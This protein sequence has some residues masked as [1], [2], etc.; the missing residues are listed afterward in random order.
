MLCTVWRDNVR[1][2]KTPWFV[3]V[4]VLQQYQPNTPMQVKANGVLHPCPPTN[5][6][7]AAHRVGLFPPIQLHHKLNRRAIQCDSNASGVHS[8]L[9]VTHAHT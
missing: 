1:A 6:S 4:G 5:T 2:L 9:T 3:A 8:V 7:P